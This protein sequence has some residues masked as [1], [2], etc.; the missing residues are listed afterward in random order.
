M[1]KQFTK[2]DRISLTVLLRAKH[3]PR[4]CALELGFNKSSIT[5]EVAS[6]RDTDGV[7]KG[8]GINTIKALEKSL[9]G[10]VEEK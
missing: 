2:E 1:Y 8:A 3:S 10:L 7:Y 5:R 4:E 6:N 9:E